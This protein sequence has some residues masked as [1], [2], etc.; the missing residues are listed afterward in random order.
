MLVLGLEQIVGLGP[1]R[2]HV[3][4]DGFEFRQILLVD[5]LQRH[6]LRMHQHREQRRRH[7]ARNGQG[8]DDAST[9][10]NVK[11]SG[12]RNYFENVHFAG[13]GPATGI[14][15]VSNNFRA[16]G[17][18]ASGYDATVTGDDPDPTSYFPSS[19]DPFSGALAASNTST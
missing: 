13:G 8:Q 7:L 16:A 17:R 6:V 19:E 14:V 18:R 5:F 9:L 15:R 2:S 3:L 10:I 12:N 1:R 4:G 11:V